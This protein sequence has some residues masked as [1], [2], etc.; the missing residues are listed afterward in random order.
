MLITQR[1]GSPRNRCNPAEFYLHDLAAAHKL[2][3]DP[4]VRGRLVVLIREF[5]LRAA[6]DLLQSLLLAIHIPL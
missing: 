1:S 6:V 2:V 3:L 4:P 5:V